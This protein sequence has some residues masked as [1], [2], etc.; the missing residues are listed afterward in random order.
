MVLSQLTS[1]GLAVLPMKGIVA[2][3]AF[4]Q[5]FGKAPET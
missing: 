3:R 5:T 1:E 4:L 2:M